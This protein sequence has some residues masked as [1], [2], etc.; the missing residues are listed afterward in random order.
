[1]LN[2]KEKDRQ[3]E[4]ACS[5]FNRVSLMMAGPEETGRPPAAGAAVLGTQS[6]WPG[7]G[8]GGAHWEGAHVSQPSAKPGVAAAA[9]EGALS[10]GT[11]MGQDGGPLGEQE[12]PSLLGADLGKS[13]ASCRVHARLGPRHLAQKSPGDWDEGS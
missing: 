13:R 7:A 8:G 9:F 10:G 1:M 12:E 6:L 3:E 2:E 4:N 5:T 11:L